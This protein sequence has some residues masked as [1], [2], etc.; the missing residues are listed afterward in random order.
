[1]S[2]YI[3]DLRLKQAFIYCGP[4]KAKVIYETQRSAPPVEPRDQL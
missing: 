4:N 3:S 2:D 1:M